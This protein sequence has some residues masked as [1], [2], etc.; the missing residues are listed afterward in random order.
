MSSRLI[1]EKK[2]P[3]MLEVS[4]LHVKY[5]NVQALHGISFQVKE[6]EIVALLGANGAGKSTTLMSV[7]RLPPPEAP[8]VVKGEIKFNDVSLLTVPAHILVSKH[9]IGLV[10]EGRHIFGNLTVFENLKLATFARKDKEQILKDFERVFALF[11]RLADRKSQR[12][13]LLSGGE[14]Q[15]LAIGRAFMSGVRFILLDEPSMGLSPLLMTEL[16][17]VLKELNG[18]GATFL[19]VEQNARI[20]LKYAH[21]AY[22]LEAGKIV[23]EGPSEA[24]SQNADI[25]KAY[26][27]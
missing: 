3:S 16:F 12:G 24:L 26:L 14:Q 8:K 19:V 27:G 4:D 21:R 2:I 5:G 15:M 17:R 18:I 1:W 25:Q 9:G 6:G 10:P 11:P 7:M 22:I 20:A 23:L 13:D